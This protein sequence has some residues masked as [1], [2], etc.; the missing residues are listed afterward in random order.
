M[1]CPFA[2]H[3]GLGWR[4]SFPWAACYN[5]TNDYLFIMFV[6]HWQSYS[7]IPVLGR[8]GDSVVVT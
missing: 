4:N 8:L 3:M 1:K 2:Y 7:Q 6:L 5:L